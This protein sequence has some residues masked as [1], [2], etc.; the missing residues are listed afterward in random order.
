MADEQL[1]L[2]RQ[3]FD[4]SGVRLSSSKKDL[5]CKVLES[6]GYYDGFESPVYGDSRD[7]K[8]HNGRSRSSEKTQYR[9]NIDDEMSIDKRHYLVC[10][11]GYENGSWDWDD[12]YTYTD[13]RD[14]VEILQEMEDDL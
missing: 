4:T 3:Y 1:D 11:D 8:D 2:I 14:I 12:A 10:D 13:L 5:L 6:P 9:I 7:H